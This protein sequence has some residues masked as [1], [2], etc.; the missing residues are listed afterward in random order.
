MCIQ[1]QT[2]T[3]TQSTQT[4]WIF[5]R[6]THAHSN[7]SESECTH[8]QAHRDTHTRNTVNKRARYG[9]YVWI[10]WIPNGHNTIHAHMHM[11]KHRHRHRR[12]EQSLP[13]RSLFLPS[14]LYISLSCPL[15]H[16]FSFS[17]CSFKRKKVKYKTNWTTR[18]YCGEEDKKKILVAS[19]IV[20]V[21]Q[22]NTN[23]V[24][25]H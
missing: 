9:A 10:A 19:V 22:S 13:S 3:R 7:E 4:E 21:L 2:Q 5:S 20:S 1:T 18:N 14:A 8:K 12:T 24:R 25:Y 17:L 15:L 11:H 16:S 23:K 6:Y